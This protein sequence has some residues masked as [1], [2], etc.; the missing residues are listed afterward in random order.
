MGITIEEITTSNYVIR[1]CV[2]TIYNIA[3]GALT[4]CISGFVQL[5]E[6]ITNNIFVSNFFFFGCIRNQA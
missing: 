6:Q 4:S 2:T 1:N 5:F 3:N